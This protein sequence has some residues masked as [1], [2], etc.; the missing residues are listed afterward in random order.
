MTEHTPTPWTKQYAN[1][2]GAGGQIICGNGRGGNN[3]AFIAE[4]DANM[5]FIVRACN[6]HDAMKAAL[7]LAELEMDHMAWGDCDMITL[8]ERLKVVRTALADAE[9]VQPCE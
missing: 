3:R 7:K 1:V 4:G 5:E 9:K 2:I 6:S 8:R